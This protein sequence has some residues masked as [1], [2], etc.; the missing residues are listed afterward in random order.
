MLRFISL[1]CGCARDFPNVHGYTIGTKIGE[2]GYATVYRATHQDGRV[3]ACKVYDFT[4][5][6][7]REQAER[8]SFRE[9]ARYNLLAPLEHRHILKFIAAST[10]NDADGR[11]WGIRSGRFLLL[12]F[13]PM[14]FEQLIGEFCVGVRRVRRTMTTAVY[15]RA[16]SCARALSAHGCSSCP[17]K[18]QP[19]RKS[20]RRQRECANATV[21]DRGMPQNLAHF[22]FLQLQDAVVSKRDERTD[23]RPSSRPTTSPTAT[24]SPTIF[25]SGRTGGSR[26]ATLGRAG[27]MLLKAS[28]TRFRSRAPRPT[29]PQR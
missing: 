11:A 1:L 15:M 18:F 10:I 19:W 23:P 4:S 29:K 6:S 16:P 20:A 24:S 13:A 8:A 26:S 22:Y 3:A 27:S 28:S 21:K 2:G 12:E 25:W 9:D 17:I 7:T 5:N 14:T